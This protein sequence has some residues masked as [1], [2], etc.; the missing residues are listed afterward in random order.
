MDY[1]RKPGCGDDS[2]YTATGNL[3]FGTLE[4]VAAEIERQIEEGGGL[5]YVVGRFAYGGLSYEDSK[6]SL[7]LFVN[8]VMPRFKTYRAAAE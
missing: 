1:V 7:D 6:R 8:E 3:I 4:T 2:R 5:N